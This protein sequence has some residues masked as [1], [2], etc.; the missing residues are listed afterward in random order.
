MRTKRP[1][2]FTFE[3]R[4]EL[5]DATGQ[6]WHLNLVLP[7]Q[8]M[9]SFRA[10][11]I[12]LTINKIIA[13]ECQVHQKFCAGTNAQSIARLEISWIQSVKPR[14]P[15]AA[16]PHQL[17]NGSLLESHMLDYQTG[18]NLRAFACPPLFRLRRLMLL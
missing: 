3:R 5:V 15:A 1:E 18:T 17:Q 10:A 9:E 14:T 2:N 12:H 16:T 11:P 6:L 7:E 13:V 8:G 4:A